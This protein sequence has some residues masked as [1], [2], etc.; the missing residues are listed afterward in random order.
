[1]SKLSYVLVEMKQSTIPVAGI[2]LCFIIFFE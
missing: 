2:V 1:M